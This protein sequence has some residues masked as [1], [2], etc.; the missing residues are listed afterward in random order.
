MIRIHHETRFCKNCDRSF[1]FHWMTAKNGILISGV[2]PI[3]CSKCGGELSFTAAC[4]GRTVPYDEP[5]A[6]VWNER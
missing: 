1:R 3:E 5:E 6:V 2:M 4:G